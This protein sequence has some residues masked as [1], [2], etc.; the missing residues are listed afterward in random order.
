LQERAQLAIAAP[1]FASGSGRDR[2]LLEAV[3]EQRIDG[4]R[5]AAGPR[6]VV[7]EDPGRTMARCLPL[8]EEMPRSP[9]RSIAP[10][11]RRHAQRRNRRSRVAPA[12][13]PLITVDSDTVAAPRS[14]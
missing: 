14:S 2:A 8:Q 4:D 13:P 1:P 5:A 12:P 11:S 7:D 9:V 10:T 3:G 6:G